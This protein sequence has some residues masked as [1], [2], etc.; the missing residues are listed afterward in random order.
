LKIDYCTECMMYWCI[1]YAVYYLLFY[2]YSW[3]VSKK[4]LLYHG[5]PRHFFLAYF[6]LK[7][8]LILKVFFVR[9]HIFGGCTRDLKLHI[10]HVTRLYTLQP[11]KI[12]ITVGY[13]VFVQLKISFTL[14]SIPYSKLFECG[15]ICNY[16]RG[17][18]I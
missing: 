14:P 18:G 13:M 4:W 2:I 3:Y 16:G 12:W 15:Y 6:D 17:A 9:N 11:S 10:Y 7:N 8:V 5:Q 1:L